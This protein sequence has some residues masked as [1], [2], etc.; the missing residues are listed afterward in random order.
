ML[1][2]WLNEG[3]LLSTG[4]IYR[5]FQK[6]QNLENKFL[7][8]FSGKKWFQR[9]KVLTPAFHFKILEQFV[10]IFNHQSDVFVQILSK[11]KPTDKIDLYPIVT[12]YALDVVCGKFMYVVRV[13]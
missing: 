3:L 9:R 11:Y 2:G 6:I 5:N 7:F 12:L 13:R 10:D 8:I 1:K 4:E